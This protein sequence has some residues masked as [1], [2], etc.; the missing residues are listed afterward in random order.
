MGTKGLALTSGLVTEPGV[1]SR[2]EA[3]LANASNCDLSSPGV[4][5]KRRGFSSNTLN[6]FSGTVWGAMS[7][8]IL[9]RDVGAG[10]LLLAT[11]PNTNGSTSL[12]Y[13][14]RGSTFTA[15]SGTW[16]SDEAFRPKLTT[17]S[18]GRD[19]V[20]L[21]VTGGESGPAV[22][23]YLTPAIRRL[24]IPRGM[25]I[26]TKNSAITGVT[27]FLAAASSCRYASVFVLGDPSV[28]GAQFGSPGMTSVITNSG[29]T[30]C[31][32]IVRCTL[33][34]QYGTASTS[35][36]AD[37]YWLQVY[38][39]VGQASSAGEPPSEMA[40][41]YQQKIAAAD[42]AAGYIQFTDIVTDALRGASLYTNILTG[43]DGV[44]GRGFINSN[45]P[46]PACT[47]ITNWND[48]LWLSYLQ[49]YPS[50]EIQLISIGGSGF[51]TGDTVTVGGVTYTGN[52]AGPWSST[53]FVL[54]TGGT[55]SE[56]QRQT[57][58]SLV[59]TINANTG[60]TSIYA[61]YVAGQAGQPGRIVLRGRLMSSSIAASVS[62]AA[63]WRIGTEDANN[64]V[65][66]AVAFSKALQPYAHPVVNRFELGRGDAAV[67]RIVPYR[68]SL[69]VFKEDGTWR[70]TGTDFRSFT[71]SEFDL[72]FRL[73]SRES[74]AVVDDA[75]YAWGTQGI[76]KV[77]DG[78]VEYI[79]LP[80]KNQV[81]AARKLVLQS[82]MADYAFAV[83]NQR[84]GV[85]TFFRPSQDPSGSDPVACRN[86]FVF[87]TRTRVWS[88][89][90]FEQAAGDRSI[91]YICATANY[92]D[93]LISLGVWQTGTAS[94]AW[95]HNERRTYASADFSD[96][97][98]TSA[99][100]PT[101]AAA[102]ISVTLSWRPFSR[103]TLGAAQWIRSRLEFA[104]AT[105]T[106]QGPPGAITIYNYGD[107]PYALPA[108]SVAAGT[109]P[110]EQVPTVYVAPVDQD[111]SRGH[112][113]QVLMQHSTVSQGFA[114]VGI[115]VDYRDVSERGVAR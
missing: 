15:F 52:S 47:D 65:P 63:A 3:S 16:S 41:V 72:T 53:Q 74:V 60:N 73:L 107:N 36:T 28:N 7:S 26:D 113:L 84:D 2:D 20:S 43:E 51:V 103:A 79:D 82:T 32:V 4:I 38:R 71:A 108:A 93:H 99:S 85:V 62:R 109:G 104:N 112:A 91:G 50:Q 97:N 78:G 19:V 80:I 59:T 102:A 12:R 86:A 33:P 106:T 67:L 6:S 77:T 23:D 75:I 1:W 31:N 81:L 58:D 42:I 88:T 37:A 11:G 100:A 57:A 9:E 46:P 115:E 30:S 70:I 29:G 39:S 44:A 105:S 14:L 83:G 111:A 110:A 18:D 5:Q 95:V 76:A 69:F 55:A 56:N 27:G 96:P 98:M 24:G 13:G 87:H 25:G 68:D 40:L 114:L 21:W 90:F 61:Y 22:L 54:Y 49:D 8:P 66:S 64:P 92:A 35:L 17:G 94:G 10:A 48:C 34:K 45:E 101:M 89:W